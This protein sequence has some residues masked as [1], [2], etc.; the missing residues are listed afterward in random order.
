MK[1]EEICVKCLYKN[2]VEAEKVFERSFRIFAD[3]NLGK[4]GEIREC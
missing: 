3:R 4:R 1:K 2:E